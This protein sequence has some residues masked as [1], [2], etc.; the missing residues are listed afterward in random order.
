[1]DA[2]L[3]ILLGLLLR[4]AIPVAITILVVFLLH[5]LDKRWQKEARELPVIPASK[6]CW[7]IEDC[8]VEKRDNCPVYIN[9]GK[10]CWQVFRNEDGV[11]KEACLSCEVFRQ[12]PIPMNL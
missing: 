6:P 4:L 1:M 12:A 7:E 5:R 8:P 11:M 10:P 3:T 2:A 9:K